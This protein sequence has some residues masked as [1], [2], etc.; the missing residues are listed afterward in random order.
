LT[1]VLGIFA[2]IIFIVYSIYFVQIIKGSQL[3]FEQEMLAAFA[4]WMI[5]TGAAARRKV[6]IL[7]ILSVALEIAYFVLTLLVIDNLLLITF[8]GAFIMLETIHLFSLI[9]NFIRFFAGTIVLKQLFIWRVERLSAMLFFT[10]SFLVLAS[11][12]FF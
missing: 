9:M 1:V 2:G 7:I 6:R 8:T 5:E 4:N 3:D 12:I 10:H 11:L